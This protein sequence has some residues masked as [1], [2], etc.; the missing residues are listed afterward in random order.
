MTKIDGQWQARKNEN[1]TETDSQWRAR[2]N[3]NMT[4]IDCQWRARKNE[5][6]P[7]IEVGRCDGLGLVLRIK[8]RVKVLRFKDSGSGRV[9]VTA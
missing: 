2:K 5:N 1:M 7:K 8:L 4:K 9:R 6:M 3:E